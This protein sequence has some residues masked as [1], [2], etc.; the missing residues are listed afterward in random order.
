MYDAQSRLESKLSTV[1]INGDWYWRPAR[2]NALV[3]IQSRLPDI[4]IGVCD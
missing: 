2:S 3:E 4:K 1:L